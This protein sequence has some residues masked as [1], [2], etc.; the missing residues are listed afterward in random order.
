MPLRWT[1]QGPG[2]MHAVATLEI[3]SPKTAAGSAS[4]AF[5]YACG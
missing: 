4:G 2:S 5:D 1:V 3:V